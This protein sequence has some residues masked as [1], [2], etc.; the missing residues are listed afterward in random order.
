M[1]HEACDQDVYEHGTIL[2]VFDMTKDQAEAYCIAETV[3][4]GHPHD[5]HYFAGRVLVKV[6][7]PEN[8]PADIIEPAKD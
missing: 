1:S 6:L 3:R 7:L 5:W 2:G 8:V 4:T